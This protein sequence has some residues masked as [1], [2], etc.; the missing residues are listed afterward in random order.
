MGSPVS[1]IIGPITPVSDIPFGTDEFAKSFYVS[2]FM[3][4]DLEIYTSCFKSNLWLSVLPDTI[5]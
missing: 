1:G 2:V 3:L 4:L 5:Y